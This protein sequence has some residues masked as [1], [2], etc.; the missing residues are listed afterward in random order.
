MGYYR[1]ALE[2]SLV[3]IKLDNQYLKGILRTAKCYLNLGD[4]EQTEYYLDNALKK[5]PQNDQILSEIKFKDQMKANLNEAEELI[6]SENYDRALH[7]YFYI[8][9][10]TPQNA[11]ANR[12]IA[13]CYLKKKDTN[14]A[15]E[16][17]RKVIKDDPNDEKALLIR[18]EAI[19]YSGNIETAIKLFSQLLEGD[20]DSSYIR[21]LFKKSKEIIK[22]KE[23]GENLF[24]SKDYNGAIQAYDKV[25]EIEPHNDTL[26]SKIY[27][28]RAACYLALKDFQNA[29]TDCNQ[30]IL[31]DENYTKAYIRRAKC[32]AAIQNYQDSVYDWQKAKELDPTNKG[33]KFVIFNRL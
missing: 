14:K 30:T 31:L 33:I 24:R 6:R 10:H 5:D 23:L 32:N 22:N 9:K 13:Y 1:D 4:I 16:L 27:C 11:S 7:V 25:L 12:G 15:L 3:S 26:N 28:N 20:P 18:A 19:Y 2:D 17:I 21:N 8:L 29:I